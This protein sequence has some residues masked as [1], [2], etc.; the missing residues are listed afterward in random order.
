ME[1][2]NEPNRTAAVFAKTNVSVAQA[3]GDANTPLIFNLKKVIVRN[4]EY[5]KN[6][7]LSGVDRNG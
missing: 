4:C 7:W 3:I 2:R 5:V 6:L 1:C